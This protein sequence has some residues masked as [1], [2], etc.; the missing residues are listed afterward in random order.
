MKKIICKSLQKME[1]VIVLVMV[2]SMIVI[3]LNGV[4]YILASNIATQ[5]AST[6]DATTITVVSKEADTSV[7]T[8]TFPEGAPL[9]TV[10]IPYN[11]IDTI[12]D[13]QVLDAV[14]GS[15]PVVRLR[16]TAGLAYLVTLEITSWTNG[17]A[18]SQG[19]ALV[20][21]ASTSI[22]TIVDNNLSTDGNA[23][24]AATGVSIPSAEYKALYLELVL[25]GVAGR[26]GT[27]T[28]SVLGESA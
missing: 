19:Y 24:T 12:T 15:E 22:D 10:S 3:S 25:S 23:A 21:T 18:A 17:V 26:T 16:N 11:N 7:S 20:N 14:G 2:V 28:L 5:E 9:A 27:S 1:I 8:I 13:A 6:A 4:D